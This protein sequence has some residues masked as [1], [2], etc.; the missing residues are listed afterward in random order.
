MTSTDLGILL[1]F[2][3]GVLAVLNFLTAIKTEKK[4]FA[5]LAAI[6][7]ASCMIVFFGLSKTG[8]M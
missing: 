2:F 6:N 1:M 5:Y 3:N 4:T 8:G 7:A